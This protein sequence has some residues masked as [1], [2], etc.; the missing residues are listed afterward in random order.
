MPKTSRAL[1][2]ASVLHIL[3][4]GPHRSLSFSSIKYTARWLLKFACIWHCKLPVNLFFQCPGSGGLRG[5]KKV[6]PQN[7]E[8]SNMMSPGRCK[9][10]QHPVGPRLVVL[11]VALQCYLIRPQAR[12][13]LL[14]LSFK[15]WNRKFGDWILESG[16]TSKSR[17]LYRQIVTN[18]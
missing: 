2:L 14:L 7:R 11:L 6:S 12:N 9:S 8:F 15:S 16:V 13:C 4:Q 17:H 10:Q 18:W 3:Q 5:S 1:A